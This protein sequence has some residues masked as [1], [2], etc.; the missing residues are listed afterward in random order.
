MEIS[1]RMNI[2]NIGIKSQGGRNC[3]A[4]K[5]GAGT[6]LIVGFNIPKKKKR[7]FNKNQNI[8]KTTKAENEPNIDSEIP[9]RQDK[10]KKNAK[11]ITIKTSS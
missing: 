1:A 2:A 5:K 8:P 11:K 3:V 7:S 10:Q 9:T 6:G 4:I